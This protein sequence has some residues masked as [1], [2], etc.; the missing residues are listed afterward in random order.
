MDCDGIWWF[1]KSWRIPKSPWCVSIQSHGRSWRLDDSWGV[2]PWLRK[3]PY[4]STYGFLGGC[5]SE[6]FQLDVPSELPLIFSN[7]YISYRSYPS[8]RVTG[9][10][11]ARH[12]GSWGHKVMP[13]GPVEK[14]DLQKALEPFARWAEK[15]RH[16]WRP[17]PGRVVRDMNG[18][19]NRSAAGRDDLSTDG[20]DSMVF[21]V[22]IWA[23]DQYLWR[24]TLRRID[25]RRW[26]VINVENHGKSPF[27]VDK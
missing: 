5:C 21:W 4:L 9:V 10:F 2:P 13:H 1:L 20:L 18:R 24:I 22:L 7:P 3:P 14:C 11:F 6:L 15:R 17:I 26:I 8:L 19:S 27:L 25:I 12:G 16:I 23:R